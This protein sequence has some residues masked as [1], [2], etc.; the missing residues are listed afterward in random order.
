MLFYMKHIGKMA[1]NV[2]LCPVT[3]S[4]TWAPFVFWK[5]QQH[6]NTTFPPLF[7]LVESVL[8][9]FLV[10]L[11]CSIMCLCVLSFALWSPL[12]FPHN[13]DV[14]FVFTSNCL[15]EGSCHIYVICVCLRIVVSNTYCVVCLVCFSSSCVHYVASVF[16]LSIFDCPFRILERL[17]TRLRMITLVR[18]NVRLIKLATLLYIFMYIYLLMQIKLDIT[19]RFLRNDVFEYLPASIRNLTSKCSYTSPCKTIKI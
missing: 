8:I 5:K 1:S 16:G 18:F 10:L 14:Q 7:F 4:W 11:C 17:F 19:E 3:V 6:T 13:N 9:I 12:R 15:S 2:Q